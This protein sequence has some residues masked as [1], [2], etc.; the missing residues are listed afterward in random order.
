MCGLLAQV[1]RFGLFSVLKV[2]KANKVDKADAP[3]RAA[4]ATEAATFIRDG[5]VT[6]AGNCCAGVMILLEQ[7]SKAREHSCF[8]FV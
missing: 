6:A 1:W 8:F 2:L 3:A 4:A 5:L 7:S